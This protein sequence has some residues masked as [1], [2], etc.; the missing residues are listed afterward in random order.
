MSPS[1]KLVRTHHDS[2]INL[3][4]WTRDGTLLR[5]GVPPRYVNEFAF[6]VALCA[7]LE[8]TEE[9]ILARQLGA[10]TAGDRRVLDVILVEPGPSFDRR[11]ALTAETI[12]H[13]LIESTLGTGRF[14]DWRRVLGEGMSARQAVERGIDI[15]VLEVEHRRGREYVKFVDR[16]PPQWF[17]RIVA[18]ENKPDLGTPGDL[19]EQLQFDVSLGIVD[20]AILV[21]ASHVTRAHRHRLP[22]PVGI[23]RFDPSSSSVDVIKSAVPLDVDA[24]GIEIQSRLTG[25][26]DVAM[27]DVETKRRLRRRL[28]ERAYGKGW[29]TYRLP[30]CAH[31]DPDGERVPGLPYCS[32]FDRV[33]DPAK[34]C[35]STCPARRSAPPPAIDRAAI[36]DDRS[37][38]V[39]NPPDRRRRQSS[40]D[41][42][43]D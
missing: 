41:R 43:A 3:L 8:A 24:T 2:L 7:H 9:M 32:H 6:E 11:A 15:G 20:A 12:P 34:E 1:D 27:V 25:R 22:D 39:R 35:S 28:A 5:R 31:L 10:S 13:R 38:W 37:P 19:Y 16:Y 4:G 29:R 14:R 36:R 17:D 40:F 33:V 42:F 30:G 21:T 18:I 26:T 23:W